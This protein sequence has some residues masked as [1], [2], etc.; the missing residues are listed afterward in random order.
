MYLLLRR[1]H[2]AARNPVGRPAEGSDEEG[3][4]Q[5]EDDH[6]RVVHDQ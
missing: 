1:E 5:T 2:V 4:D 3:R 6:N